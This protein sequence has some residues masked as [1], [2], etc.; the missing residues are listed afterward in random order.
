MMEHAP[1]CL[2]SGAREPQPELQNCR[3]PDARTVMLC[4]A[5][6]TV[7]FGEQLPGPEAWPAPA[8]RGCRG[9]YSVQQ[10]HELSDV[11]TVSAGQS[12]GERVARSVEVR[13]YS[14]MSSSGRL[15]TIFIVSRLTVTIRRR[16]STM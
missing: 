2:C 4:T 16:R 9:G 7:N 15:S 8:G 11:V 13:A 12:N 3:A 6:A 5:G 14:M 1:G 10:R